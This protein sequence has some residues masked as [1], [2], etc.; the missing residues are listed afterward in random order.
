MLPPC[1]P[2]PAWTSADAHPGVVDIASDREVAL[3]RY[4][5]V[6]N[7][8]GLDFATRLHDGALA[9]YPLG[10]G[11]ISPRVHRRAQFDR[12]PD[13]DRAS[14]LDRKPRQHRSLDL[15]IRP[16]IYIAGLVIDVSA[17]LENRLYFDGLPLDVRVA[18]SLRK[19]P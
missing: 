15:Q 19:R 18:L 2:P 9:Y 5:A 14:G 13:A 17:H 16:Y 6:L 1:S 11:D 12:A 4:R 3:C 7:K 8:L 10:G